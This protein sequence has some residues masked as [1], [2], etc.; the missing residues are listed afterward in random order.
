MD[1]ATLPVYLNGDIHGTLL[2]A[3]DISLCINT[4]VTSLLQSSHILDDDLII[5]SQN[6]HLFG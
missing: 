4:G 5:L 1:S 6:E 2:P 3:K